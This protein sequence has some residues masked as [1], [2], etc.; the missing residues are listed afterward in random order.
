MRKNSFL[1]WGLAFV[2]LVRLAY[3]FMTV[4]SFQVPA[5]GSGDNFHYY[6]MGLEVKEQ[7]LAF[8]DT[9]SYPEGNDLNFTAPLM[10]WYLGLIFKLFGV[11][12]L[13]VVAFNLL[14]SVLLIYVIYRITILLSPDFRNGN[15]ALLIGAFYFPFMYFLNS[16]GKEILTAFLLML[17]VFFVLKPEE[18]RRGFVAALLA[19]LS[20][21]LLTHLD[22]RYIFYF[23]L[24]AIFVYIA[25]RQAEYKL[26]K[27][28]GTTLVFI[29]AAG[30]LFLPWL[31]RNYQIYHKPV[32]LSARL[33]PFTD[34]LLG[35][36]DSLKIQAEDLS[37]RAE[38]Y[39]YLSPEQLDSITVLN[40][41]VTRKTPVSNEEYNFIRTVRKPFRYT[42]SRQYLSHFKDLWRVANLRGDYIGT[43]FRF[44]KWSPKR[45]LMSILSYGM[46]LLISLLTYGIFYREN[47]TTALFFICIFILH[48]LIHVFVIGSGL[49]RYRYPVDGLLIVM[50]AWGLGYAFL[51]KTENRR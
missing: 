25:G 28:I 49:T 35:V 7:G 16:S 38:D 12:W 14:F 41:R 46:L 3:L 30:A 24:L 43:G 26:L 20:F 9:S 17:T 29:V 36:P 2:L 10:G 18:T 31:S 13:A 37:T 33:M 1:F 51:S 34:M 15:L 45:N 48:T 22:E 47:R 8:R 27:A 42:Q 5:E 32:L 23:P 44:D 50:S 4:G 6:Q 11:N 19:A 39:Q 21:T 40:A